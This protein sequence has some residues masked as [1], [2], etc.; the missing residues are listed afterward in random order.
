MTIEPTEP[1]APAPPASAPGPVPPGMVP[2]PTAPA[3]EREREWRRVHRVTPLLNAWKVAAALVAI[4]LFQSFDD[5]SHIP[6][7][8]LAVVGLVAGGVA[9]AALISLVYTYFAWRRMTYAITTDA[10]ILRSGIVFRS[11]RVARL[12]R[13]QSVEITQPILGRIFGFAALRIESAGGDQAVLQLSYLTQD[14]AASVRNEV[15]ARAAGID[16]DALGEPESLDP[17]GPLEVIPAPGDPNLPTGP[18]AVV[19]APRTPALARPI[20]EAPEREVFQVAPGRLVLS[21]L[22]S[23]MTIVFVIIAVG[24]IVAGALLHTWEILFGVLA[25]LLGV[26]SSIWSRFSSDFGLRVATSPDGL[27]VR[28]GLLETKARTIPPD[29]VQTVT[30]R[31]GLLWRR[32][33]WW[34]VTVTLATSSLGDDADAT[35][36]PVGTHEEALRL[37][38]LA[39]PGLAPEELP[40][41]EAGLTGMDDGAGWVPSPRRSRWLDPLAYRRNAFHPFAVALGL[42]TGRWN[43]DLTLVPHARTQSLGLSQGPWERRLRLVTFKAHTSSAAGASLPHL[44]E[45]TAAHL[46]AAQSDRARL[47]RRSAGPEMWMRAAHSQDTA[48]T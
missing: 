41:F 30:I 46:L 42:R 32:V 29:R 2:A 10:V 40:S 12:T 20:P 23:S 21:L 14:E 24:V 44:D 15:L 39:V 47:A 26:G 38:R 48:S 16:V 6:L 3:P 34:R 9:L 19:P 8:G 36:L 43:R 5:L 31:Q 37:V 22:L 1:T 33:G 4:A 7:P 17:P 11:E 27:R 35:L 25:G 18:D 13:I 45:A 28:H